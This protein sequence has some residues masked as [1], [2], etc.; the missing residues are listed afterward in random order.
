MYFTVL[1]KQRDNRMNGEVEFWAY[2]V[3]YIQSH[4]PNYT[5][6]LCWNFPSNFPSFHFTGCLKISTH[7]KYIPSYLSKHLLTEKCQSLDL[8]YFPKLDKPI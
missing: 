7:D 3:Q 4:T 6:H 8:M 2:L 5:L 1:K